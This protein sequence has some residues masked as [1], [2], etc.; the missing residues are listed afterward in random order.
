MITIRCPQC[1]RLLKL[2]EELRGSQV[3]CPGCQHNFRTPDG[4]APLQPQTG[5]VPPGQAS[6][7][8]PPRR[9]ERAETLR[10]YEPHPVAP[11]RPRAVNAAEWLK[12]AGIF[13]ILSSFLGVVCLCSTSELLSYAGR[14]ALAL[15]FVG[16]IVTVCIW[17]GVVLGGASSLRRGER[18]GLVWAAGILALLLA[19]KELLQ[20]G[21]ILVMLGTPPSRSGDGVVGL[22]GL[23]LSLAVALIAIVAGIKTLSVLRERKDSQDVR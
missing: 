14:D 6:S 10:R 20:C 2:P 13:G 22:I 18:S 5:I 3:Q 19:I 12:S 16:G 9:Q 7:P 23:V 4:D 1:R 15:W 11:P 17:G 21:M 8:T